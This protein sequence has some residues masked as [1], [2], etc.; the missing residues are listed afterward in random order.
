QLNPPVAVLQSCVLNCRTAPVKC[1]E[2]QWQC[3]DDSQC[4]PLSWRCDGKEDCENG[5]DED[6]CSERKC[7]PH[8]YTC[9]SSEC[10]EPRQLCN[11]VTNC[12]DR[13]DEGAGCHLRN[14]SS[15]L[16][17]RCDHY[18][19]TTPS[20]PRCFCAAGFQPHRNGLSCVDIDECRVSS[21]VCKHIC[22]NTQGSYVCHC[23]PGFYLELDKRSCK[24]EGTVLSCWF[25]IVDTYERYVFFQSSLALLLC[26]NLL[27]ES[28]TG[29]KSEF[30]AVD[31]VGKNMYWVDG[32]LGQILAVKLM[33]IFDIFTPQIEQAGMDGS[34]R[35]VVVSQGLS[36]PVS[37]AFDVLDNRIYWADE[38]L[39]CIGSASMDG[40]NVKVKDEKHANITK[41]P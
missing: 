30:I 29:V 11:R 37:L 25:D 17:P 10:L 7:A 27:L 39:R 41:M 28:V 18:C 14:C 9:G 22:L 40:E 32:L 19:V 20:G 31:W 38:K 33:S 1:K 36:W 34:K 4:I 24:T 3:G 8:L 2:Y 6:Q 12:A 35:K 5:K 16:A 21:G 26:F 23:H 13:S 15:S